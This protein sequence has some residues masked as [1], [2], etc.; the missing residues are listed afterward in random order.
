MFV[1]D[2]VVV[3]VSTTTAREVGA[4]AARGTDLLE[5]HMRWEVEHLRQ[6]MGWSAVEVAGGG[7]LSAGASDEAAMW[8]LD[9][10]SD[11]DVMGQRVDR[12]AFVTAVLDDAVLALTLPLK[13]GADVRAPALKAGAIMRTLRRLSAPVDVVALGEEVKAS[14]RPWSGCSDRS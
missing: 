4:P 1:L 2:D 13:A 9:L 5:A 3:E 11:M 7:L 6:S 8:G 10:P 14:H 12:L